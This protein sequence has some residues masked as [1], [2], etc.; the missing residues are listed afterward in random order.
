MEELEYRL[1]SNLIR[2]A[3]VNLDYYLLFF[4]CS[5]DKLLLKCSVKLLDFNLLREIR[6]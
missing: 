4:A 5:L 2:Y 6:F 1:K 3:Q